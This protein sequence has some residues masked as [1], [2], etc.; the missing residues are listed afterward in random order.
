MDAGLLIVGYGLCHAAVRLPSALPNTAEVIK[1]GQTL[2]YM[3]EYCYLCAVQWN[4][5][6]PKPLILFLKKHMP[7]TSWRHL[8]DQA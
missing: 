5:G 3:C 1:N 2:A 8:T 4:E 7:Q 6:L